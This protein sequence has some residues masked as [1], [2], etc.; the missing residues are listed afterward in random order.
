M[1]R[2]RVFAV[3]GL[4][5]T[6]KTTAAKVIAKETESQY[7]YC[8]DRNRLKKLRKKFDG[9]PDA[10]RF[11]FY[12]V[13]ALDT[14]FRA[15]EMRKDSD[16]F[17]DRTVVSTIAYHRAMGLHDGWFK[18]IPKFMVDQID[19][20]LYFTADEETRRKLLIRRAEVDGSPMTSSDAHSVALS[21]LIDVEYRKII[22]ERTLIVPQLSVLN[23]RASIDFVKEKL[24]GE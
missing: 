15:E 20:M 10:L 19:T 22:P 13:F 24:Y 1:E 21:H 17:V 2:N 12:T 8:S 23:P 14:Y 4:D 16:V 7:Y 11:L 6:G 5:G 3:E 18:L 9:A